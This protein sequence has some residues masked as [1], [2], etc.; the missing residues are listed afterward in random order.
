MKNI[1]NLE[2]R[3]VRLK[4]QNKALKEAMALLKK[5]NSLLKIA[6]KD[7][8]NIFHSTPVGIML[9]QQG[10][11]MDVNDTLL[12]QLG[13]QTDEITGRHFLSLIHASQKREVREI[14]KK[15]ETGKMSYNQ[16][17]TY[18]VTREGS[19][20]YC[21]V[22]ARCIRLKNRTN[23]LLSLTGLESRK[24]IEDKNIKSIRNGAQV[25]MARGSRDR[26]QGLAE[27]FL[28]G[29]ERSRTKETPLNERFGDPLKGSENAALEA[30]SDVRKLDVIAGMEEEYPKPVIFDLNK[31]IDDVVASIKKDF[32]ERTG[33]DD[34][35]ISTY[36]RST[37]R[38]KGNPDEF[39]E[40]LAHLIT[41]SIEAMSDGGDIF[42]TAEEN[43]KYS[44]IYIQDSGPGISLDIQEKIFDPFFGT[45]EMPCRGLGLSFS[46]AIIKRHRGDMEVSSREGQGTIFQIRLP[47]VKSGKEKNKKLDKG[48]IKNKRILIIQ[49]KDVVREL[50]THLLDSKGCKLDAADNGLEGLGILK[51]KKYNMVIADMTA[52]GIP[53][54]NFIKRCKKINSEMLLVIIKQ[55]SERDNSGR[56]EKSDWGLDIIKPIDINKLVEQSLRLLIN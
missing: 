45:K 27:S 7:R 50:L 37:S 51:R 18:L 55:G 29:I 43:D 33:K 39:K 48:K 8:E 24:K 23:F 42:I 54:E 10:K 25:L 47:L 22:N 16:Y 56:V 31:T 5:E 49:D 17:E 19:S 28:M 30:L 4:E 52:L 46:N 38:I 32:K 2:K 13:Y 44:Y 9:I 35:K 11:I 6:T 41:N 3:L 21:N 12:K 26:L 40:A 14:H 1:E 34:L 20:L 15:W 36:L 53:E